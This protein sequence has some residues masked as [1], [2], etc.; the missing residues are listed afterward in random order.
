[1]R[2]VALEV[3]INAVQT[4]Q[5][6]AQNS[7]S[8][9]IGLMDYVRRT[10]AP[11]AGESTLSDSAAIQNK[12]A[13]TLTLLFTT[14]YGSG[15]ETF[16]Q[17]FNQ[18][19]GKERQAGQQ[20]APATLLY[21]RILTSVH[22]EIADVSINV[23]PEKQKSHTELKDLIRARDAGLIAASWKDILFRWQS[24][25]RIATEL[26]LKVMGR[27]ISWSDISLI[28]NEQVLQSLFQIAGQ[29]ETGVPDSLE[30]RVRDAAIDVFTE[31]VSKKMRPQEKVELVRFMSVDTV[32]EKLISSAPLHSARGSPHYDT[33]MAETVAKL[34]NNVI[35]DL[36]E[37][38]N[39]ESAG[40][41]TKQSAANL[42]QAFTPYLL[43]FL[44]DEYDEV[45][46]T[47][48]P[49]LTEQLVFFRKMAKQNG[50]L[51]EPYSGMILP[52]LNALIAK[53]RY[54]DTSSWDEEDDEDT[55]E[56]EF[57]ELRKRLKVAQQNI[58]AIDE[59][60]F[61][62]TISSL[63]ESTFERF[64]A[65]RSRINW[66]DLDLAMVEMHLVGEAGVRNGGLYQKRLPSS[67]A[68]KR[69]IHLMKLMLQCGE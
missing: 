28:A 47:I 68:S 14:L 25:D 61:L 17:D 26:C 66:R 67:N 46:S 44:S 4:Q 16:F 38:L 30:S 3:V 51:V 29:Q 41:E 9:K 48:I 20:H 31:T 63:V 19:S 24:S 23:T 59:N 69:M 62:E 45:C 18:L 12:L 1:M 2:H 15:W 27:W 22:D 40:E 21:L 50:S 65:D 32:V 52:I 39:T 49:A 57:Q 35:W 60:L 34:V 10:Y 13:Q 54:D 42:L 7:L 11:S 56:A 64:K 36:I 6:D 5:L 43:R 55:D 58:A 8:V 33:D 37:V 53:T